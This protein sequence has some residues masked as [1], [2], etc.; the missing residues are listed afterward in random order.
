MIRVF[1][2]SLNN[3]YIAAAAYIMI[4]CQVHKKPRILRGAFT[5]TNIS[6]PLPTKILR[7]QIRI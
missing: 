3:C 7:R 5:S 4:I 2:V 1:K 6:S